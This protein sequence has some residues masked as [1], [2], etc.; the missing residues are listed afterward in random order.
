M[1]VDI[2]G[3]CGGWP[4]WP[5]QTRSGQQLIDL[6][7]AYEI[8][9]TVISSTNCVFYDYEA[10]NNEMLEIVARYPHRLL[11]FATIDPLDGEST[12]SNLK[13]YA[14]SGVKGVR[15]VPQHHLYHLWNKSVLAGVIDEIARFKLPVL[16]PLR[17]VM[18]QGMPVLD[19][20]EI[21]E[22]AS[23]YPGT[24]IIIA[25]INYGELSRSIELLNLHNNLYVEI[26][27]L[28]AMEAVKQIVGTAGDNRILFGSG[29]PLQ[30][31]AMSLAKV[32][33]A[34]IS[35]RQKEKIFY[36]NAKQ[37]LAMEN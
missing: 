19:I 25:G 36:R 10:G 5:V 12:I 37:L 6:M 20:N 2:Y 34:D 22:L 1:I 23:Q 3:F 29:I 16:I 35:Q 7:D 14:S 24:K 32:I 13:H 27:C 17:L 8:D 26:S 15:L 11:G 30:Y 21:G 18:N 31:P 4:Y 28:Q 9:V 33:H